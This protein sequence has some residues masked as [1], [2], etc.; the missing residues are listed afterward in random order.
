MAEQLMSIGD[1][2]AKARIGTRS[3]YEL[4]KAP[5]FPN[6]RRLAP[7]TFRWLESEVDSHFASLPPALDRLEPPELQ[8][9]KVAAKGRRSG[10]TGG[11]VG[12]A[13]SPPAANPHRKRGRADGLSVE[14]AGDQSDS[15]PGRAR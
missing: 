8:A 12:G 10:S 9:G 4:V 14:L 7:R 5:G 1:I 3:A 11:A 13:A 2:A 6:A 15:S